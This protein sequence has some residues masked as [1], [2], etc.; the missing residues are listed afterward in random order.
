M[1]DLTI[2]RLDGS[3]ATLG[4]L[5]EGRVALVVNV[6]SECDYT[7]QYEPL[8]ALQKQFSDRGFTVIGVPCNQFDQQEPGT[9]DEIAS[10]CSTMY[11]VTFPLTEKV[12]VNGPGRHPI[13][14][15][16]VTH[17][18]DDGVVG[19]IDWNFEKFLVT[20]DGSVVRRFRPELEPDDPV[21][22]EAIELLL[23]R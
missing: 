15:E 4:T 16:L 1:R 21:I 8:E 3:P 18:Y 20:E 17:P 9:S 6:A 10:F 14:D 7:P 22:I 12:K 23:V 13:Y 19:D 2:H 11:G 5:M